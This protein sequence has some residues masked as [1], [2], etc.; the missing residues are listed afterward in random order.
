M[1]LIQKEK[2]HRVIQFKRRERLLCPYI[3][4]GKNTKVGCQS[5]LQGNLPDP[6][7]E[8]ASLMSPVLA[9]RFFTMSTTREDSGVSYWLP[10]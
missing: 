9:N 3:S 6:G 1:N 4:Q 5:L 8:P 7:V 2:D 10:V